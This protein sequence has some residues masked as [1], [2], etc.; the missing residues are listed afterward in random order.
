MNL[1]Q[2]IKDLKPGID[3]DE[4][5][6]LMNELLD[7]FDMI[8]LVV[9]IEDKIGQEIQI[10]NINEETFKSVKSLELFLGKENGI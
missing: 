10:E 8:N 6:L 3:I 2:I 1:I 9:E 5:T 7:S 4:E